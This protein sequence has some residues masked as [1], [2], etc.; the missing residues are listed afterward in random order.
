MTR[1][2]LSSIV[3]VVLMA[4]SLLGAASAAA[5]QDGGAP[6]GPPSWVTAGTRITH[7]SAVA[8]IDNGADELVEDPA[9]PLEDPATGRRYREEFTGGTNSDASSGSGAGLNEATIVAVEGDDVV[10]VRTQYA[11]DPLNGGFASATSSAERVPGA[12]VPGL[13][14]DPQ[15]LA[16]YQPGSGSAVRVLRGEISVAGATYQAVTLLDPTPGSYASFTY[17]VATG[18]LL[19][20]ATRISGGPGSSTLMSTTELRGIRHMDVP[21]IGSPVPDWISRGSTLQYAG[22]MEFLNPMDPGSGTQSNPLTSS[23]SFA[24][25]GPTWARFESAAEVDFGGSSIPSTGSGAT[26]GSGPYWWDSAALASLSVGQVLDADPYTG[27]SLTVSEVGQG[28]VG[29]AVGVV[30]RM[31]GIESEAY[32]D[33]ATGVMLAQETATGSSGITNRVRLLEMP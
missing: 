18:V 3:L 33:T 15:A 6:T 21:G 11:T 32:Y 1:R 25:T 14:M 24:E 10:V 27:F 9:G 12:T 19:T 22:T 5:A 23:V 26:A 28:P 13:W 31:P 7:A 30:G 16:A 20:A 8:S 29:S 17:D 2:P 4:V